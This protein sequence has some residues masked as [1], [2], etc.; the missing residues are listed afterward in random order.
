MHSHLQCLRVPVAS[1]P[2]EHL[3][4]S[5]FLNLSHSDRCEEVR[6]CAFK[7]YFPNNVSFNSSHHSY[8]LG[9]KEGKTMGRWHVLAEAALFLSSIP[10]NPSQQLLI[11]YH[12]PELLY[13]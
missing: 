10:E 2:R 1:H 7:L 6:H 5:F 11:A 8:P 9:R 12:R 13:P 4:L 3:A